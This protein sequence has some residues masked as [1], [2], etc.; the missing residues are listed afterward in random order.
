MSGNYD[1]IINLPRHVSSKYPQMSMADRAAQFSPF[2]ALT[3]HSDAIRE[4]ERITEVQ[5][6]PSQDLMDEIE[7]KL[8]YIA[9]NLDKNID[10][11]VKFFCPDIKKTGGS[12]KIHSGIVDKIDIYSQN[13]IFDD[14]TSIYL[15]NIVN[16]YIKNIIQ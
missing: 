13:I 2:A 5:M 9:N 1:D 16:L 4:E 7:Y 11:Q 15:K 10:V 14:G 3:G 8:Q 12:Y 6:E